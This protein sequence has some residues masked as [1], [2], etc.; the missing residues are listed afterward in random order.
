MGL[1]FMDD[2]LFGFILDDETL[3]DIDNKRLVRISHTLSDKAIILG[4]A[5]L[6]ETLARLLCCLLK[7]TISK[8]RKGKSMISKK[9]LL[10]EVWEAH[11][12]AG[13]SQLL[14]RALRELKSKLTAIGMRQEFIVTSGVTGYSIDYQTIMPLYFRRIPPN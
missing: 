8:E 5:L 7:N 6:N 2:T 9:A 14:W 11:G 4:T 3:F 1:I 12:M 13:S 10:E